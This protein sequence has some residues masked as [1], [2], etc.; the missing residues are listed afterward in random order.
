MQRHR[1]QSVA[2]TTR[3]CSL[4]T[5]PQVGHPAIGNAMPVT[6]DRRGSSTSSRGGP[7]PPSTNLATVVDEM[8]GNRVKKLSG[9]E[10]YQE[11]VV[12]GW[13]FALEAE[14][15]LAGCPANE[16]KRH[17][18]DGGEIGG[19]MIGADTA[20][21]ISEDHVHDPVQAVLAVGLRS[22]CA[23]AAYQL[24][25]RASGHRYRSVRRPSLV[26]YGDGA[27]PACGS[28]MDFHREADNLEV[29]RRK[30]LEIVKLLQVR[31]TDLSSGSVS[32]P[33]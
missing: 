22:V 21:V 23:P 15:L 30:H 12:P 18:L 25:C 6:S 8:Q 33:D 5:Y 31:V 3:F 2:S 11:L 19:G 14:A 16:V 4:S 27:S 17:V 28:P 9:N 26:E 13:D 20:L 10:A 24:S 29:V 7:A 32:L 1:A